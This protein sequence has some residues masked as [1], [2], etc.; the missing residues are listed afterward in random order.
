MNSNLIYIVG[1]GHS[2]STL[3]AL[4]I[5]VSEEVISMGEIIF[6]NSYNYPGS[7]PKLFAIH[8][9]SCTCGKHFS[10]CSFWKEINLKLV[11]P[12]NINRKYSIVESLKIIWNMSSPLSKLFCFRLRK[13]DDY[14]LIDSINSL[15]EEKSK[16]Y[17]YLL[18]S[19]KDPRR[20]VQ[21]IQEFGTEKIKVVYIVRDGR[22]YVNSYNNKRKIRVVKGG[23]KV[24]NFFLCGLKWIIF[25]IM[26]RTYLKKYNVHSIHISYD[27]FC[28]NPEKYIDAINNKLSIKIP[29][30]YLEKI[31]STTFHNIHGNLMKFKKIESI[32]YDNS[33]LKEMPFIKK[34]ILTTMLFPFNKLYSYQDDLTRESRKKG[35]KFERTLLKK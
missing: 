25:N 13:G 19:S 27:L 11:R 12:I 31:N 6:F 32:K 8:P 33:W 28:K 20:L 5:G 21:L 7:D 18:D 1:G 4:I 15:L 24:Q 14:L 10:E 2:G 34:S 22:G 30:N 35:S 23:Q 26:I 16:K 29:K 17:K 9:K 3:L